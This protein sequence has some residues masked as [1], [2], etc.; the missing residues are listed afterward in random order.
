MINNM[1]PLIAAMSP[2]W[3][4]VLNYIIALAFVATVPCI[5]RAIIGIGGKKRNV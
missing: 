2:M 3:T 1:I 4:Y 5:L